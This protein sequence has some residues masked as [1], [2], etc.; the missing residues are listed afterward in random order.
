MQHGCRIHLSSAQCFAYGAGGKCYRMIIKFLR[1]DSKLRSAHWLP[2]D[3]VFSARGL[4]E[5]RGGTKLGSG[6]YNWGEIRR[7]KTFLFNSRK[8]ESRRKL[9]NIRYFRYKTVSWCWLVPYRKSH[10]L[11]WSQGGYL[12]FLI[13]KIELL[14]QI[15]FL[16]ILLR[17]QPKS[18]LFWVGLG[19]ELGKWQNMEFSKLFVFYAGAGSRVQVIMCISVVPTSSVGVSDLNQINNLNKRIA[20]NN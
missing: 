14:W 11:S 17:L 5:I 13:C 8:I 4:K 9:R 20:D 15:Q 12:I 3:E 16:H 19:I 18:V 1:R 10:G 6:W 7:I 2:V